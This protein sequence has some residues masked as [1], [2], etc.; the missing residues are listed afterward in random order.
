MCQQFSTAQSGLHPCTK[1]TIMSLT[2]SQA[3]LLISRYITNK[4]KELSMEIPSE[5][6]EIIFILYYI[7]SLQDLCYDMNDVWDKWDEKTSHK[8]CKIIDNSSKMKRSSL[9]VDPLIFGAEISTGISI[10][11]LQVIELYFYR[12]G[13]TP[14][15]LITSM[16]TPNRA[17]TRSEPD[18]L[19]VDNGGYARDNNSKYRD[20]TQ[21]NPPGFYR[22]GDVVCIVFNAIDKTISYSVNKST[23][24]T[25]F[26]DINIANDYKLTVSVPS[27][28]IVEMQ[29]PHI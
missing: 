22:E 8:A 16:P 17:N 12:I 24:I 28:A 19:F 9:G 4:A 11:R 10:W 26:K 6:I 27:D 25:V 7:V 13:F 21:P 5:L 20:N 18:V 29:H 23:L 2:E 1:G 15:S 14:S 3:R